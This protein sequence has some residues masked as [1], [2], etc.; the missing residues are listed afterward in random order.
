MAVH[1]QGCMCKNI[2][3]INDIYS[4][5]QTHTG[6]THMS[7]NPITI[8]GIFLSRELRL[9]KGNNVLRLKLEPERCGTEWELL[10][11]SELRGTQ[12]A[13]WRENVKWRDENRSKIEKIELLHF[14]GHPPSVNLLFTFSFAFFHLS[15][16]WHELLYKTSH[17]TFCC[18]PR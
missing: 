10:R 6:T 15:F 9:R 7:E 2:F 8:W 12:E 1:A 3:I 17:N 5:R 4:V 11:M 13:G 16:S 14:S 18:L